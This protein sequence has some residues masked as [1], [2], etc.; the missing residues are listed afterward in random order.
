SLLG[1]AALRWRAITIPITSLVMLL[2]YRLIFITEWS[3]EVAYGELSMNL[4]IEFFVFL[5]FGVVVW[6]IVGLA[7]GVLTLVFRC[8]IRLFKRRRLDWFLV[9]WLGLDTVG[10]FAL[11]PFIAARRVLGLMV[12]MTLILGRLASFTCRQSGRRALIWSV[13]AA[14]AVLGLAFYGT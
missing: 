8:H 3:M 10:Y 7:S 2:G 6:L 13:V 1:L 4:P 11:T 5:F 9:M 14:N 12:V